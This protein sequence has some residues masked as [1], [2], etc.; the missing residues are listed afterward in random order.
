MRRLSSLYFKI[1]G[2]FWL[3]A[4]A[5]VALVLSIALFT[6]T[7]PLGYRW[8]RLTQDMYAHTAVDFYTTGGKASLAQYLR[9]LDESSSMDARLLDANGQDLLGGTVPAGTERVLEESSKTGHSSLNLG[10]SWSAATPVDYNNKR[11]TFVVAVHPMS[12]F[13]N[14]SF[15]GPLI[16][17]MI[18]ALVVAAFFCFL[19]ARSITAPIRAL[20]AASLKLESGD[21]SSRV[22]PTIKPRNDEIADTARAFD[23]MAD[24]I[25]VLVQ[26]RQELLANISH[27]L[28]SPLTRLSVSLELIRRGENDVVE[29]MQR[30]LD[31][32]NDMIGQILLLTRLDMK[33]AE[34]ARERWNLKPVLE[35]IADDAQYERQDEEKTILLS[36][37]SDCFVVGDVNLLRSC[38]EN[39]V[40]NAVNYT[41]AGT[42]VAVT[43]SAEHHDTKDFW[44]VEVEDQGPGVPSES[45]PFLF[46]P[47]Y[48]VSQSRDRT[49][50]GAGLGL[51]IAQRVVHVHGGRISADNATTHSGLNVQVTLPAF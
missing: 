13:V 40:R 48:R 18:L 24:R 45:L 32:L 50:G 43:V 16:L 31:R 30:D 4:V 51:A 23:R 44:R 39:I 22:L 37:P 5:G 46:D 7:Q 38:F 3:T 49:D 19:L 27:E 34:P 12:K 15:A 2:W 42:S 21:F 10:R 33:E 29:Q 9:V 41:A 47:F 11:Y 6:G 28:R 36:A 26:K 25:E 20:Q 8:M 35:A 17:R 14:G 1:F